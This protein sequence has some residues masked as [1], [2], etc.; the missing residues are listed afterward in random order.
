MNKLKKKDEEIKETLE[1]LIKRSKEGIAMIET[2][3]NCYNVLGQTSED[4]NI[5]EEYKKEI[6]KRNMMKE[7]L[8]RGLDRYLR[9]YKEQFGEYKEK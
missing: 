7:D 9:M 6:E 3:E 1:T 8:R 2:I 4:G 5:S